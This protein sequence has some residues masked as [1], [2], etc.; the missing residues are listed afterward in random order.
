MVASI[1]Q[2]INATVTVDVISYATH[3]PFIS[4]IKYFTK[5]LVKALV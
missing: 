4:N 1:F 5:R 3:T 2:Q